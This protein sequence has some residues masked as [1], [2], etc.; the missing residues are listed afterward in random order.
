MYQKLNMSGC[1][2]VTNNLFSLPLYSAVY[3]FMWVNGAPLVST[4]WRPNAPDNPAAGVL[5]VRY[6]RHENKY[7]W[8]DIACWEIK[9]RICELPGD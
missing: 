6:Q 7:R 2:Y 5:C 3:N 8:N 4:D 1:Y 9:G